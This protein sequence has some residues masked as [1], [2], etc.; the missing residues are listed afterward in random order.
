MITLIIILIVVWSLII[1]LGRTII[2]RI[3]AENRILFVMPPAMSMVTITRDNS[4]VKILI[5]CNDGKITKRLKK[6]WALT[7]QHLKATKNGRSFYEREGKTFTFMER[8]ALCWI[9]IPWIYKVHEWYEKPEDRDDPEIS[10]EWYQTLKERTFNYS[11]KGEEAVT[12]QDPIEVEGELV[13]QVVTFNPLKTVFAVEFWNEALR[14]RIFAHWRQIVSSLPYFKSAIDVRALLKPE[15][16]KRGKGVFESMTDPAL[17][18]KARKN[19]LKDLGLLKAGDQLPIGEIPEKDTT[20]YEIYENWGI[21]FTL[22][23]ADINVQ[24]ENRRRFEEIIQSRINALK[25]VMKRFS[26]AQG[27]YMELERQNVILEDMAERLSKSEGGKTLLAG[28]ALKEALSST[29]TFVAGTG[30]IEQLIAMLQA[31]SKKGG[32]K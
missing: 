29:D 18:K 9:G 14:A 2:P 28:R 13:L 26:E 17:L 5:N 20:A 1:I 31:L 30:G 19:L 23:I 15:T 12:T 24:E 22:N 11:F 3:I 25:E 6:H 32:S 16:A 7:K 8:G 10:A 4:P 21:M 27:T